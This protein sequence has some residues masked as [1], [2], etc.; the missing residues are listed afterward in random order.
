MNEK[1]LSIVR[2]YFAQCVFMN[3]I[4]YKAYGRLGKIQNRNRNIVVTLSSV[5]LVI[6][7]LKIVGLEQGYEKLLSVLSFVGL[8]LTGTSLI[9][10]LFNKLDTSEIRINHRLVAEEYKALRDR[11]M[12]LIEETMSGAQ[13]DEVLR[14]KHN[15]L[16]DVYDNLGKFSPATTGDDYSQAQIGLGLKGASDEEFTWADDEIDKF[17]PK[18]LRISK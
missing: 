9:F 3:N 18:S 14:K 16:L 15:G 13:E 17:L 8:M 11:Y 10:S 6:L 5:T 1:L 12:V 7:I 2:F 4:H